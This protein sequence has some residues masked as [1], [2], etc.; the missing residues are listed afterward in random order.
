[1]AALALS[2]GAATGAVACA[3]I[4]DIKDLPLGGDGGVPRADAGAIDAGPE[5]CAPRGTSFCDMLCPIPD[6]CEDFE[7]PKLA[8]G[9][10]PPFGFQ[11]PL[12]SGGGDVYLAKDDAGNQTQVLIAEA[13]ST[14]SDSDTS[15]IATT[16]D[17]ATRGRKLRGIRITADARPTSLSFDGDSGVTTGSMALLAFGSQLFNQGVGILFYAEVPGELRLGLQQR[18]LGGNGQRIELA[19]VLD[20]YPK[21]GFFT[22][23]IPIDLIVGTPELLRELKLGC[24]IV[25]DAGED[26]GGENDARVLLKF[27]QIASRCAAFR[28]DLA[29]GDWFGSTALF[30]GAS[31]SDFGTASARIDNVTVTLL[32]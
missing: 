31:V 29:A 22:N 24:T 5:A 4:L 9:W 15:I 32:E 16:L 17:K 30:V 12:R 26:A 23:P 25:A 10:E 2:I 14:T 8:A 19:T 3:S 6:F 18:T 13:R 27:G 21:A 7:G 20:G 28:G 1:M 11:N